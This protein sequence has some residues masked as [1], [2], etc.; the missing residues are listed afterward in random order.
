[1]D[2]KKYIILFALIPTGLT[3]QLSLTGKV[4]YEDSSQ[5]IQN[6]VVIDQNS[7]TETTTDKQGGFQLSGLKKGAHK[8][9][10]YQDNCVW[11]EKQILLEK[12]D[13]I[14]VNLK[15]YNRL[16]EVIILANRK[17]YFDVRRLKDVEG[18]AIYAGKKTEVIQIDQFVGNL[19]SGNARQIYS[20]IAGLNIYESNNAGLQLAIGGRGLS[21]NRTANFNTRQNGYDISADA[22]GYPENYYTPPAEALSEIQIVRGAASLQYGPQFGGL[23]NFITKKPSQKAFEFLTRQSWDTN[24]GYSTFNSLSGTNNKFSHYTYFRYKNNFGQQ[25]R[26][27]SNLE[28]V[29]FATDLNYQIAKKTKIGIEYT[30]L[31]Y[32][33]KLPGGLSDAQFYENSKFSNR[34]RNWFKVNWN[35]LALK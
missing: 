23:I 26:P 4:L 10:F 31:N 35:L 8:I 17:K 20:Q 16:S 25:P 24:F 34:S 7:G 14:I 27:N 15:K 11:F 21:P 29:N 9:I 28:S 22:I 13:S 30:H 32:L 33:N 19:S 3:A 6:V 1:M 2:F 5:P 18:T 12:D